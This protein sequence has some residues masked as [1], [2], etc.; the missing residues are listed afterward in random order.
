MESNATFNNITGLNY[1]CGLSCYDFNHDGWDDIT[2]ATH[3]DGVRTFQN[4]QGVF[5][6]LYLFNGFYGQIRGITWVDFDH[7]GDADFFAARYM[8]SMIIMR[9]DGDLNFTDIS[10]STTNPS[11]QANCHGVSWGDYDLDG[12]PDAYVSNYQVAGNIRSWLMH[13]LGNG[14]F[15]NVA[16]ALGVSNGVKPAFQSSWMDYDLDGDSDLMVINDRYAGNSFYRNNGDGS[17][18]NVG[19]ETGLNIE[20]DGMG[21]SWTDLDHDLDYDLYI[22]NTDSGSVLLMNEDGVFHDQAENSNLKFPGA[23]LIWRRV[24]GL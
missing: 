1:A 7:D 4:N 2:F 8:D 13:N 16:N 14:Q 9:N 3:T 12:L 24:V 22:S 17:F 10:A 11:T 18:T 6:E 5:E 15:E 21:I 23:T 19:D 20:L